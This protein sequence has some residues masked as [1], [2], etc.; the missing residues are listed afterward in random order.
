MKSFQIPTTKTA[1]FFQMGEFN[2]STKRVIIACHGYAQLGEYFLKWF[3]GMDL[4]ETVVIAPEGLHR[5]YWKGFNGK[6]VASWMTK[7]DREND[8]KDYCLFLDNV[9]ARLPITKEMQVIALGFSQGAATISRWAEFTTKKI[10]HLILWA[11]VFPD[12]V[13]VKSINFK[14]ETPVHV[15]FG[16]KD[17]FYNAEQLD[18]LKQYLDDKKL[19]YEFSAF[20]GEHKIYPEPLNNL[21]QKI[22]A[23]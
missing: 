20:Q 8:I 6:V 17:V 5:F 19:D 10:H 14:L 1:R 7:E 2:A 12:D 22:R 16:N 18:Q 13:D 4:S 23:T 3:E 21:L 11:G 9:Y 15:T